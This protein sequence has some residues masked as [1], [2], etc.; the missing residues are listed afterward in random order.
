MHKL[1][2][3]GH[4]A[5]FCQAFLYSIY[6]KKYHTSLH[7]NKIKT[8]SNQTIENQPENPNEIVKSE[9]AN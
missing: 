7:L 8:D 9:L 2:E 4:Y 3:N 1:F 6:P 5:S